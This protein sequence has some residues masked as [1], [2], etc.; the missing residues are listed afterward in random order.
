LSQN[1]R[2][3]YT[4]TYT[5]DFKYDDDTVY[6]AYACPYTYSDLDNDLSLM[7][8]QT[9][10]LGYLKPKILRIMNR[11]VLCRTLAG[12][13]CEYVTITSKETDP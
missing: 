12:N 11:N 13:K 1:T 4:L 2:F 7:E 9:E 5:Y 6:F 10:S 3:Y 8:K